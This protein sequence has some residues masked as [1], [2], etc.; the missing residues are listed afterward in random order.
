MLKKEK[1]LKQQDQ[2]TFTYNRS[3]VAATS[4][5]TEDNYMFKPQRFKTYIVKQ[6]FQIFQRFHFFV[7]IIY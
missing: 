6:S 5:V 3:F 7:K 4:I 2:K 1:G